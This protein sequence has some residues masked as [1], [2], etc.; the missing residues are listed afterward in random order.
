MKRHLYKKKVNPDILNIPK[1]SMIT[2]R[3]K[4]LGRTNEVRTMELRPYFGKQTQKVPESIPDIKSKENLAAKSRL[5]E[6]HSSIKSESRIL[7]VY[8]NR[9]RRRSVQEG[10]FKAQNRPQ[11]VHFQNKNKLFGNLN[12][13]RSQSKMSSKR[14]VKNLRRFSLVFI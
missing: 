14:P 5:N 13:I 7:S 6:R 8:Q 3:M 11:M 10:L 2:S 1:P 4:R 12:P 9:N